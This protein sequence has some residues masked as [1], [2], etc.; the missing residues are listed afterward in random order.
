MVRIL[1]GRYELVQFVGRGGMGE[2]WEGRDKVIGRRVA[3]KLLP[4]DRRDIAGAALFQRE[5]RTAGA[6]NHPGV[7]TVHDFG[8]DEADGSLFLVMEFVEGRDL[9]TVLPEDGLPPVAAA[10]DWMA[11]T[12][13]ALA[14]AHEADVVHR[15]LKPANLMLAPDGK[16]KI[17]DFGIARFMESLPSSKVMGTFPYMPPERFGGHP[18]DARSDLYS[19]GCV[20]YELLTGQAPFRTASPASMMRAHLTEIPTPPGSVRPGIPDSLDALLMELLAKAPAERP[21]SAA[22]V[23]DRLRSL[24]T[25][26]R[27][28]RNTAK[29]GTRR[30]TFEA[31]TQGSGV[32]SAPVFTT[33]WTGDEDP[34]TFSKVADKVMGYI[35]YGAAFSMSIAT[36]F[37][38]VSGI[39]FAVIGIFFLAG[40]ITLEDIRLPSMVKRPFCP[41]TLRLDNTGVTTSDPSGKRHFPWTAIEKASIQYTKEEFN[42]RAPLTLRLQFKSSAPEAALLHRPAGWPLNHSTPAVTDKWIPV[43]VLGPLTGPEKTDLQ[44]ALAIY[45][46]K[47]LEGIW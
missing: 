1:G 21:A 39:G 17:L 28:P 15:D 3:I 44:N 35:Y 47:P 24:T 9:G 6:L 11:Q 45:L 40:W 27:P 41:R 14:R 7:V 2:V 42:N 5:A 22:E 23:H 4:H 29:Q 31:G 34:R 26:A 46:K 33:S 19:L 16:V 12:A 25:G 8:Q 32:P 43:C 13:A 30:Q 38:D 20:L 36:F 37:E 10:V 18:G